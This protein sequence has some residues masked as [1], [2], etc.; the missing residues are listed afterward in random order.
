MTIP[1]PVRALGALAAAVVAEDVL[2]PTLRSLMVIVVH[3][4]LTRRKIEAL[5]GEGLDVSLGL[6]LA[7]QSS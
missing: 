6:Q 5:A 4:H 7:L 3:P 1:R 2:E